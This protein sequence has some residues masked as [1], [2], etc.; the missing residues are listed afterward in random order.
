MERRTRAY[1]RL[2][3]RPELA[4]PFLAAFVG[5]DAMDASVFTP[6]FAS[7]LFAA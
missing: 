5:P 7:Q 6:D 4:A 1:A 3:E 2:G